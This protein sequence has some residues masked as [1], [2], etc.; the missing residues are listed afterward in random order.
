MILMVLAA[1]A[2]TRQSIEEAAQVLEEVSKEWGLV[3]FECSKS[4]L[5]VG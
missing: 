3:N 2:T 4:K 1:V 5:S